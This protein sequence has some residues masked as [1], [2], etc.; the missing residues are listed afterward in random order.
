MF[1]FFPLHNVL[2]KESLF[3][4]PYSKVKKGIVN[5][6]TQTRTGEKER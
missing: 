2:V 3:V 4:S 1:D 5:G 6:G